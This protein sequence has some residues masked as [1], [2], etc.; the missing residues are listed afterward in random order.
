[1]ARIPTI[2]VACSSNEELLGTDAMLTLQ[3][4]DDQRKWK[5]FRVDEE[6]KGVDRIRRWG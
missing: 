2:P 6:G 3:V 1:M 5:T 4:E